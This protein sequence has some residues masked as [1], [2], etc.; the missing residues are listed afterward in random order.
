MIL[1]R[2]WSWR[3]IPQRVYP[4]HEQPLMPF[5]RCQ[6][7]HDPGRFFSATTFKEC[8]PE[9]T[10]LRGL[11][12]RTLCV[13]SEPLV[14]QITDV[15]DADDVAACIADWFI[16]SDVRL[17]QDVG[18]SEIA[19][20]LRNSRDGIT[21][22]VENGAYRPR[23]VIL[24]NVRCHADELVAALNKDRGRTTHFLLDL[25]NQHE[26]VIHLGRAKMYGGD[27]L[28]SDCLIPV[29][30]GCTQRR[31]LRLEKLHRSLHI[32]RRSGDHSRGGLNQKISSEGQQYQ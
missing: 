1:S 32:L 31:S 20:A 24:F 21:L 12:S 22:W 19:F 16:A 10:I 25:V 15:I 7:D 26:V 14:L 17:A 27:N 5:H 4:G 9:G 18:L 8:R 29:D 2:L 13:G 3:Q 11:L 23:P 28:A 6:S 30:N